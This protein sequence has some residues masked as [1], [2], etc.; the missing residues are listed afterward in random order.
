[1]LLALLLFMVWTGS[2]LEP[3]L[4]P[5][6]LRALLIAKENGGV[7]KLSEGAASSRGLQQAP[8]LLRD[9]M[10]LCQ[11]LSMACCPHTLRVTQVRSN[12]SR[13]V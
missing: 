11:R 1:V 8:G 2:L 12:W 7:A 5:E 10:L 13:H 6:R 3:N 9:V 4:P